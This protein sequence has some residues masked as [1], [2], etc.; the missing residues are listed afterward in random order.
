MIKKFRWNENNKLNNNFK[1]EDLQSINTN[2]L[3]YYN[4]TT[5]S[6]EKVAVFVDK[7]FN[8]IKATLKTRPNNTY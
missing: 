3:I 4:T 7:V 6:N 1:I 8:G 2:Y 5:N